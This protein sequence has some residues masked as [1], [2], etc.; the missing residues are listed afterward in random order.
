M[1]PEVW[2][3]IQRLRKVKTDGLFA[4]YP[5]SDNPGEDH[6]DDAFAVADYLCT[7]A[8]DAPKPEP[9][10]PKGSSGFAVWG[11]NIR[12]ASWDADFDGGS[13]MVHVGTSRY[14]TSTTPLYRT[15]SD[16]RL[17]LQWQRV[18]ELEQGT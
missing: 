11:N 1:K 3:A 14:G 5:D 6:C 15:E 10:D 9:I 17:A 4:A 7:I 8:P 18:K 16:A 13:L 2:E 12:E